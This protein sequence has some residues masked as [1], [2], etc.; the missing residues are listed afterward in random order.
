MK[1]TLA[2]ILVALVASAA[3]V[4]WGGNG[5]VAHADD[6]QFSANVIVR[7][8][9]KDSG[10]LYYGDTVQLYASIDNANM[11]YNIILASQC[12]RGLE[13]HP[14]RRPALRDGA[15]F[16][17]RVPQLSCSPRGG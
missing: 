2:L 14:G 11:P 4:C 13:D 7:L 8:V 12:W 1:R 10:D 3:V 5:I 6:P 17:H 15:Y 9:G 16:L